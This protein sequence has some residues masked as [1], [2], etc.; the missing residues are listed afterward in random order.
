VSAL[1]TPIGSTAS[2]ALTFLV[3]CLTM[4]VFRAQTL[5]QAG[6]IFQRLFVSAASPVLTPVH[7]SGLIYTYLLVVLSHWIGTRLWFKRATLRL[8]PPVA[9]LGYALQLTMTLL[10]APASG[11]AFIYF[12]F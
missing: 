8:S 1:E 10:L 6:L 3:V 9:G 11:K 2:V 7:A 4:I 5:E 12:Q